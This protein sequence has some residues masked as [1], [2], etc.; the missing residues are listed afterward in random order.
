MARRTFSPVSGRTRK[1]HRTDQRAKELEATIFALPQNQSRPKL[2]AFVRGT[3]FQLRVWRGLLQVPAGLAHYLRAPLRRDRATAGR[4]RCWQ[5]GERKSDRLHHPVSSRHSR[6]RCPR[7]L[8]LGPDLQTHHDRLGNF[9]A[10]RC[11]GAQTSNRW[12]DQASSL[13][14]IL[15]GKMPACP[16]GRLPVPRRLTPANEAQDRQSRSREYCAVGC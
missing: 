4:P 10:R 3:P 9:R 13:I 11:R 12:G 5:R 16:T 2:R 6:D 14:L 7:E 15:E 8:S 1:L